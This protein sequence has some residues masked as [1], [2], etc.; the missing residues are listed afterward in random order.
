MDSADSFDDNSYR[1]QV[2]WMPVAISIPRTETPAD[3]S[4]IIKT[5]WRIHNLMTIR[6]RQTI[7]W[8]NA[9]I[10]LI[11]PLQQICS[12]IIQKMHLDMSS[13]KWRPFC[14]GVNALIDWN[15][16]T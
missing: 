7:I 9:G 14:P 4:R 1:P 13:T 10:L 16:L 11:G 6:R 2:K 3:V 12:E 15:P 8:T 5:E